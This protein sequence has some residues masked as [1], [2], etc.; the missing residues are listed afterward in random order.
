LQRVFSYNHVVSSIEMHM[1]FVNTILQKIST[2]A[3]N[4]CSPSLDLTYVRKARLEEYGM[5][6]VLILKS[7]N[8]SQFCPIK[9]EFRCWVKQSHKHWIWTQS[10]K[11][12]SFPLA[13]VHVRG[14]IYRGPSLRNLCTND[15]FSPLYSI[16]PL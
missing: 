10:G 6:K 4:I 16:Q 3:R 9:G 2:I 5:T 1:I 13:L 15:Y 12:Y 14:S 8:W 7:S 11:W